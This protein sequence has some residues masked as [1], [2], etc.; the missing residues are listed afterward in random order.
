MVSLIS[1]SSVRLRLSSY[2]TD[3]PTSYSRSSAGAVPGRAAN[4]AIS[5]GVLETNVLETKLWLR[6]NCPLLRALVM[7]S[8]SHAL[9]EHDAGE[10]V[11]IEVGR[12]LGDHGGVVAAV[13]GDQHHDVGQVGQDAGVRARADRRSV[14]QQVSRRV[15][16]TQ[17]VQQQVHAKRGEVLAAELVRR[18]GRYQA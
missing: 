5:S 11:R 13:T 14:Q 17:R 18:A 2:P 1:S 8:A 15:A 16:V 10:F 9:V 7:R 3:S 12:G 6:S 4:N